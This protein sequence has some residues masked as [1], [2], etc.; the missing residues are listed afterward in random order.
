MT[1]RDVNE[2]LANDGRGPCQHICYNSPG[3]FSCYCHSGFNLAQ[4]KS[5]CLRNQDQCNCGTHGRCVRNYNTRPMCICYDGYRRSSDGL[6]CTDPEPP[7]HCGRGS[8]RCEE[9]DGVKRCT[10]ARGYRASSD[11]TRCDDIDECRES[12]NGLADCQEACH[13]TLGSYSC[14]CPQR[15]LRLAA[16]LRSCEERPCNCGSGSSSCSQPNGTKICTCADGYKLALNGA[17]C[18]DV[19][20]C[21]DNLHD[22]Q[23]TCQNTV[24]SY[25]CSCPERWLRLATDQRSCEELPCS[26]GQGSTACSWLN[27]EKICTCADGYEPAPHKASCVEFPCD[28]GQGSTSCSQLSGKKICTCAE[29]YRLARNGAVCL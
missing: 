27:G 25:R 17:S 8:T 16:D 14:D 2:C 4:D 10:C 9:I 3:S 29:G 19:N 11:G 18:I 13:N 20:E 12:E 15:W 26:C 24:G 1:C 6:R 5:S 7:C 21:Q 22:C 28:C 23:G